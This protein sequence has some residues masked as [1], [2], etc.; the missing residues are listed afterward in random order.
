[1][2]RGTPTIACDFDGV[3]NSYVSGWTDDELPDPPV[4]GAIEWLEKISKTCKVVI[5]TARLRDYQPNQERLMREWFLRHGLSQEALSRLTFQSKIT[6]TIYLDDRAIRFVG[7]N[8]PSETQVLNHK[9]WNA[10][11]Q[12]GNLPPGRGGCWFCFRGECDAY[13]GEFDTNL[14]IRCLRQV[15][16]E[17]PDHPEAQLMQYL[18]ERQKAKG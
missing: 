3:I 9:A 16:E 18:L 6:A 13:D 10:D 12:K 15:L 4:P 7:D 1:M 5:Y 8:F 11:A 17:Y 14:H 2:P